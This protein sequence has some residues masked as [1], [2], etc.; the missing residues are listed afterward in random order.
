M[1]KDA[2][3]ECKHSKRWWRLPSTGAW[4]FA[5]HPP[6][7]GKEA[8]VPA[9]QWRPDMLLSDGARLAKFRH[10]PYLTKAA[11]AYP[12][13]LNEYF[14]HK[15]VTAHGDA[16]EKRCG[17]KL[18]GRWKN[19]LVRDVPEPSLVNAGVVPT[20]TWSPALRGKHTQADADEG[21]CCLGGMR[22]P[23]KAMETIKG[24][25]RA[26]KAVFGIVNRYLEENPDL[27]RQC[28]AALG[29]D[30]T[31][32]RPDK[33]HVDELARRL[34]ALFNATP[35][36]DGNGLDFEL[37][38]AWGRAAGDPDACCVE[39]WLRGGSPAR[40]SSHIRDPGNIFPPDKGSTDSAWADE[41]MRDPADHENYKSVDADVVAVPE[42]HR[43][44]NSGYVKTF[45][46]LQSCTSWLGGS[47][48]TSKLAMVSKERADGTIKRRLILDCRESGANLLAQK[49]GR[50]QLPRPTDLIDDALFLLSRA[51]Q[52]E[53]I[54]G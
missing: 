41:L 7:K 1:F 43:L 40:I 44:I 3:S 22:H 37:L 30:E 8:Y 10:M 47:P 50:V 51:A 12:G 18:T 35:R 42:I 33:K 17:W 54:Q 32:L 14:A 6:L 2:V 25:D 31:D 45:E 36:T 34:G 38:G 4:R 48:L 52:P 28:L 39:E 46:D 26:G 15:L 11:A 20:L 5:A 49:G 29:S 16:A 13:G 9:E 21:D 19:V 27:Q 24:F 23:R 53:P